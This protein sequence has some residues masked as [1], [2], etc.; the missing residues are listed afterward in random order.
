MHPVHVP[1]FGNAR[2]GEGCRNGLVS[3]ADLTPEGIRYAD[4]NIRAGRPLCYSYSSSTWV[5]ADATLSGLDGSVGHSL[6]PSHDQG[7]CDLQQQGDMSLA[8]R[9]GRPPRGSEGSQEAAVRILEPTM[10]SLFAD[11]GGFEVVLELRQTAARVGLMVDDM[12]DPLAVWEPKGVGDTITLEMGG[13][14]EGSHR[15]A[16]VVLPDVE[17]IVDYVIVDTLASEQEAPSSAPSLPILADF[18]SA[19]PQSSNGAV[20]HIVILSSNLDANSQTGIFLQLAQHLPSSRFTVSLMT[21]HLTDPGMVDQFTRALVPIHN[22]DLPEPSSC[23]SLLDLLRSAEPA[24]ASAT[25]PASLQPSI[26]W[27]RQ[28]DIALTANTLGDPH[29]AIALELARLASRP[30][31]VLELPNTHPP[32][33]WPIQALVSP[34][35][36]TAQHPATAQFRRAA[37]QPLPLAVIHPP[38][39]DSKA[40]AVCSAAVP[41]NTRPFRVAFIGRLDPVRSPGVFLH[42]VREVLLMLAGREDQVEFVVVG[43]GI[44]EQETKSLADLLLG[45]KSQQHLSFMGQMDREEVLCWYKQVD[46]LLNPRLG[47]TFGIA[48]AEAVAAG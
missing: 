48:N 17:T 19:P 46:L 6:D 10:G 12:K 38:A 47:E 13:L 20:H 18:H 42:V 2:G 25:V 9:E 44:L 45:E 41:A 32:L 8:S 34:S 22:I 33:D 5:K 24:T 27:L 29:T 3:F 16:V 11:N 39:L 37:P 30:I 28:F 1:W 26:D 21:S 43:G 23:S 36:F 4:R 14:R 40:E 31:R 7:Q 35:L 15:L